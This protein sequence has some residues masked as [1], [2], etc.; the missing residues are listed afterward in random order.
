MP[1][2]LK[3][4]NSWYF[5]AGERIRAILKKKKVHPSEAYRMA[6]GIIRQAKEDKCFDFYA[7]VD[8]AMLEFEQ[9]ARD[10]EEAKKAKAN[11]MTKQQPA[12]IATDAQAKSA[13]EA[14][15]TANDMNIVI[16]SKWNGFLTKNAISGVGATKAAQNIFGMPIPEFEKKD[17]GG[18][19]V[20]YILDAW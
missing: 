11:D 9:R 5:E 3:E 10:L 18:E 7:L 8:K 14:F 1:D 19:F 4:P 6:E 15:K 12:H 17:Y 2:F 20:D 16:R 13:N